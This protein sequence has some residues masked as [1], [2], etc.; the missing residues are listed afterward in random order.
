[1]KAQRRELQCDRG[2][3]GVFRETRSMCD[4]TT[5]KQLYSVCEATWRLRSADERAALLHIC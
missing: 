2:G 3:S 5:S 1:M 4:L